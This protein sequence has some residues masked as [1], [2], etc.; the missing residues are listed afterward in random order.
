MDLLTTHMH[1]SW[2]L[3]PNMYIHM[4]V[5][6]IDSTSAEL[7]REI[8]VVLPTLDIN[9]RDI[10]QLTQL[11]PSDGGNYIY[12]LTAKQVSYRVVEPYN[13]DNSMR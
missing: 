6:L 13:G 7:V 11:V 3:S 2:Y 12:S 9:D 1:T 10:T 4:Q 5:L 8:R